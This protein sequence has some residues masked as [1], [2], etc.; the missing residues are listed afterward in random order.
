MA[1]ED[2]NE[3]MVGV[4]TQIEVT[5]ATGTMKWTADGETVKEPM[6]LKIVNGKTVVAD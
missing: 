6:I 4:M 1:I 2:F 3:K 5:G